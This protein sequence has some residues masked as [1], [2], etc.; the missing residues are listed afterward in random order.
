M[1]TGMEHAALSVSNLERSIDFY[2][3]ILGMEHLRTIDAAPEMG[4]GRI[5]GIPGAAA[6]IAHLA[7]R[8]MML[9]LF[10]YRDPTGRPIP[11]D[12]KQADHGFIHVAFTSTDV[13]SDAQMLRSHAV[14]FVGEPVEFRP[15]VWVLYFYGPDREVIELRQT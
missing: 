3:G 2:C 5:V 9:E 7:S 4:L 15:G 10:E 14:D 13:R 8:T 6:R 12:Q 1:I 11:A